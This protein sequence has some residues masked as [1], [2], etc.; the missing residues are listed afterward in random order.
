MLQS[1]SLMFV[2]YKDV[3]LQHKLRLHESDIHI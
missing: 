1:L 3:P 2:S